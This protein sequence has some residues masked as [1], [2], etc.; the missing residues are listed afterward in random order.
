[1]TAASGFSAPVTCVAMSLTMYGSVKVSVT[2]GSPS[3]GSNPISFGNA[4]NKSDAGSG[5]FDMQCNLS[6]AALINSIEYG[7]P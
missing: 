4:I 6:Y 7:E 5:A 1:V 3:T 2:K